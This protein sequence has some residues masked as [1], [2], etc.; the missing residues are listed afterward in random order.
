[1]Y[2]YLACIWVGAFLSFVAPIAV[3]PPYYYRYSHTENFCGLY[4]ADHVAYCVITGLYIPILSGGV[5][6]YTTVRISRI[7][8]RQSQQIRDVVGH[9]GDGAV[10]SRDCRAVKV[11]GVTSAMYFT[12]WGPYV[13]AAYAGVWG[14]AIDDR[15]AFLTSWLAN[16]NSFWNVIIY[17]IA[18]SGFRRELRHLLTSLKTASRRVATSDV[19]AQSQESSSIRTCHI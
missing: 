11:L 13:I 16:S 1:M 7:A 9:H 15:V 19:H 17:Y 6:L 5:I 10:T 8:K 4:W 12:A 18:N 3:W 14:A 2:F